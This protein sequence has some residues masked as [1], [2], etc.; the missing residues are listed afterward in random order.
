MRNGLEIGVIGPFSPQ[1]L[2]LVK[3]EVK[4]KGNQGKFISS[5]CWQQ[6]WASK[7]RGELESQT[8]TQRKTLSSFA[9]CLSGRD[10]LKTE[11]EEGGPHSLA[12]Q[13]EACSSGLF[14]EEEAA[15]E[16]KSPPSAWQHF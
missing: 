6:L 15:R 14:E 5:L 12:L 1:D 4:K 13:T 7:R 10:G 3:F 16:A 2:T 9:D 8:V 11:T